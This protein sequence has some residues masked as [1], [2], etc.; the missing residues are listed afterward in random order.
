MSGRPRIGVT[1]GDPAGIG[2]E[3]AVKA[4]ADPSL[5]DTCDIV[6]YGPH[7]PGE[8]ARFPC[9]RISAEAGRAAYD[10]VVRA[11]EDARDR[12]IDAVATAP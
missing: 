2:P 5:A 6:L 11:V 12:R 10:A 9:G 8:I 3:I 1:V 7:Q 4:A